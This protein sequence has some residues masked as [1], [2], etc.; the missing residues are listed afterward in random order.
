M[1]TFKNR[2]GGSFRILYSILSPNFSA[3]YAEIKCIVDNRIKLRV[4]IEILYDL[5][6]NN[7]G[8]Y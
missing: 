6:Y 4:N 5:L 1:L 3:I 7:R 2:T 8:I